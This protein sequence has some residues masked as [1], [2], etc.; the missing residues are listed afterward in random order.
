MPVIES[1]LGYV[2]LHIYEYPF[3][4]G[5]YLP[6]DS[7][8]QTDTPCLVAWAGGSDEASIHQTCLNK[9]FQ[10]WFNIAVISDTY[11]EVSEKTETCLIAAFNA[12]CREGQW[13]WKMKN[14]RSSPPS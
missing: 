4:G 5:V 13:L 10:T 9:G 11:D 3:E 6:D 14:Y 12:D 2:L 1:Q 7:V 8:Y